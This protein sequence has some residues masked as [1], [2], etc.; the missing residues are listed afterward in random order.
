MIERVASFDKDNQGKPLCSDC[1]ASNRCS[2][3]SLRTLI[4]GLPAQKEAK[5]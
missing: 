5:R 1:A 3:K 4:L 2:W